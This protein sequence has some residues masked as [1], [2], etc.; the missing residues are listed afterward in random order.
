M[1]VIKVLI[2]SVLASIIEAAADTN[3]GRFR[4]LRRRK[5][6][7]VQ[8]CQQRPQ[9]QLDTLIITT[10]PR[11]LPLAGESD[12]D[13]VQQPSK[14]ISFGL[15]KRT[16]SD[17]N[18]KQQSSTLSSVFSGL[19]ST[20]FAGIAKVSNSIDELEREFQKEL[21][22]HHQNQQSTDSN[23]IV[24]PKR[25]DIV[26][27]L[28]SGSF[29]NFDEDDEESEV[30]SGASSRVLGSPSTASGQSIYGNDD[31]SSEEARNDDESHEE[32]NEEPT[33]TAIVTA[34]VIVNAPIDS[35]TISAVV[36]S[37]PIPSATISA[38]LLDSFDAIESEYV[39]L[40]DSDAE[41]LEKVE[42]NIITNVQVFFQKP[43]VLKLLNSAADQRTIV[44][45]ITSVFVQLARRIFFNPPP[46]GK[47]P[48]SL[49]KEPSYEDFVTDFSAQDDEFSIEI[50]PVEHKFLD[51]E[52]AHRILFY[53]DFDGSDADWCLLLPETQ[54]YFMALQFLDETVNS[55]LHQIDI[56]LRRLPQR[57]Y[58]FYAENSDR[59]RM[60]T[61]AAE[62]Q[63][64]VR[65]LLA[66]IMAYETQSETLVSADPI[67]YIQG[68]DQIAAYFAINFD[69]NHAGPIAQR[70]FQL[71]LK[72]LNSSKYA[73][74]EDARRSIDSRAV[75]IIRAY[76]RDQMFGSTELNFEPLLGVLQLFPFSGHTAPIL[77][78]TSAT[79]WIDLDRLVQ[80][81]LFS[82]PQ[83]QAHKC[84][85]LLAAANMV[86]SLT[87]LDRL[88]KKELGFQKWTDLKTII[89]T[90]SGKQQFEI[91]DSLVLN[92]MGDL[93]LIFKDKIVHH[94]TEFDEFLLVAESL[95]PYLQHFD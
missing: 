67:F 2:W 20:A 36:T 35:S 59:E 61:D 64:K 4:F 51:F 88:F 21:E 10:Q 58:D 66:F 69:L 90:S 31:T 70:F 37:A 1:I 44:A 18:S 56:D 86:Y 57:Y 15:R 12:Q 24:N 30:N 81:L 45:F 53:N 7:L 34:P 6:S 92:F 91:L 94:G 74:L 79:T 43:G 42:N 41:S 76:L 54:D 11:A 16:K 40:S 73:D 80:F 87:H 72:E 26:M 77:Y 27:R 78:F 82:V 25:A 19:I 68:F 8:R 14:T 38:S 48:G 9:Q 49:P 3:S 60:E 89:S 95:V 28:L 65:L 62:L 33:A 84:I 29:D 47:K 83:E 93:F 23:V 22:R 71:Y 63:E 39:I 52:T 75:K 13:P 46:A 5:S 85:S 32:M 50:V 55:D 17:E